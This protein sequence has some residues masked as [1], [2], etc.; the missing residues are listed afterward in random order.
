MLEI[1]TA[2]VP[3]WLTLIYVVLSVGVMAFLSW[4]ASQMYREALRHAGDAGK[5]ETELAL[6]REQLRGK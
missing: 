4:H 5:Y 1:M 2:T 6:L 3:L